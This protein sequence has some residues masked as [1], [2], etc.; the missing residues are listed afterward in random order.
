[1][2]QT[3]DSNYLHPHCFH[4]YDERK[5]V[6]KWK[7]R[8]AWSQKFPFSWFCQKYC[9][10]YV[11]TN[12]ETWFISYNADVS[13]VKTV[14]IHV[15]SWLCEEHP[16]S[17]TQGCRFIFNKFSMVDICWCVCLYTKSINQFLHDFRLSAN[18]TCKL[19]LREGLVELQC[20]LW[21][22]WMFQT[23]CLRLVADNIQRYSIW[24][25]SIA[26]FLCITAQRS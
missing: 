19:D 22:G 20:T 4:F 23:G 2:N 7:K 12:I 26:V 24:L 9:D 10:I 13:A 1:M 16:Y 11:H 18:A 6:Y 17:P 5:V 3:G 25:H 21:P 15:L 8:K 14:L